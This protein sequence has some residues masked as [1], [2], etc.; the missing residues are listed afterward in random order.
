MCKVKTAESFEF[1]AIDCR[2]LESVRPVL[3]KFLEPDR[4]IAMIRFIFP[5]DFLKADVGFLYYNYIATK[6]PD[7]PVHQASLKEHSEHTEKVGW[8]MFV[9]DC[10]WRNDAESL[11]SLL[12]DSIMDLGF[13][14]PNMANLCLRKSKMRYVFNIAESKE[15]EQFFIQTDRFTSF[16]LS[17]SPAGYKRLN[18]MYESFEYPDELPE[19]VNDILKK[20]LFT[21]QRIILQDYI[22]NDAVAACIHSEMDQKNA[23][24]IGLSSLTAPVT[25]M[26]KTDVELLYIAKLNLESIPRWRMDNFSRLKKLLG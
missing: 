24:G 3:K 14:L 16:A 2:A 10:E 21:D 9:K 18:Q 25:A 11:F 8:E 20:Y 19:I 6:E 5:S 15:V 17:T 1:D 4:F 12:K 7:N 22:Y 13:L 26:R 23:F